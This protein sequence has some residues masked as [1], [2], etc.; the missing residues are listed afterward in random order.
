MAKLDSLVPMA[1][2][3]SVPRSIEFYRKVGFE[4]GNTFTPPERKEP[5][6]AWLRSGSA[7]LMVARASHPVDASQ[8]AVLFYLYCDD[9]PSFRGAL[10]RQGLAVGEI[11]YPF[12]SPRGEFRLTDPDGY[13]LMI[14]HAS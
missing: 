11:T 14:S 2:V 7:H 3:G 9:V 12:Y 5:T 10:E 1:F 4:V 8:Q 13:A 6:W